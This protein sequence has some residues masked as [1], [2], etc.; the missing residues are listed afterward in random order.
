MPL[1]HILIRLDGLYGTTAVLEG[2]LSS[3]RGIIVRCKDYGLLDVATVAARLS[4][5][6]GQ[7]STH[8]ESGVSRALFDGPDIALLPSLPRVRLIIATH[9]TTSTTKPS[10]GVLRDA[11][12]SELFLT[13][14][15]QA[16]FTCADVLDL[17]LH[18]GSFETVL[19][20]EDREQE[21]DRWCSQTACGQEF[22]QIVNQ[23]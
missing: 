12:V 18:R 14:A 16:A 8:P 22:W 9:P 19:A 13:T 23:W 1:S 5:P 4:Q 7:Y 6:P 21:P 20:D 11:T 3:G 17:Y 2:L 10:I 15:P